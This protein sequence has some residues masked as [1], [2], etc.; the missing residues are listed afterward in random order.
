MKNTTTKIEMALTDGYT[1]DGYSIFLRED[2]IT[3]IT[4]KAG[5]YGELSD[6]KNM[7][8]HFK[9]LNPHSKALILAVYEDDNMFSKEVREYIAGMEVSKIVK[10]DAFVINGLALR[11]FGNIY[12]KINKPKRPGK[13]F[14]TI[15]EA[16]AWLKEQ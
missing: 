15:E 10:A 11:I 4:F 5:F 14:K 2:G 8:E 7:V 13:L 9:K 6:A 1:F 16:V 12:L 3:Q